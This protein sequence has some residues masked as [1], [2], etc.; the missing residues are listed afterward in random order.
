MRIPIRTRLAMIYCS[1][2]CAS[3]ILLE[4]G[5]YAALTSSIY[6]VTDNAL[7]ARLSGVE[8][9]L[10]EHVGRRTL[11]Q[12]QSE[13]ATHGALE[14]RFL[15][16]H[17]GG[18]GEIFRGRFLLRVGDTRP[19]T[20]AEVFWNLNQGGAPLRILSARRGIKNQQ[21]DLQVAADLTVPDAM[22]RRFLWL[23]LLTSPIVFT[24]AAAAGYWIGKRALLPV[25][26]LTNAARS[27]TAANLGERLAVSQSGD[28]VQ[29]LAETLNDMLGRIEGA[30]RHV[31]QFTANASHE[32]R[33][34]IALIRTASEVA[35]LRANGNAETYREALHR[36]LREAEKNSAL[37][38]DML[39]LARADASSAPLA[40][41]PVEL[42]AHINRLCE[43]VLPLAQEKEIRLE[44]RIPKS[45][46]WVMADGAH[47]NRLCLILL[48]NAIKY[49][50][51]GGSVVVSWQAASAEMAV[52]QVQDTGIGISEADLPH[53]FERFFR[54]DKARSR[55]EG[56]AGLGLALA[57]WIVEAHGAAIEVESKLGQG[58]VFRFSLLRVKRP[59]LGG[60]SAALQPSVDRQELPAEQASKDLFERTYNQ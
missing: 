31:T 43:R 15:R 33:A 41:K 42:G 23:F 59:G 48:D 4:M 2:F 8:G 32:L 55:E 52:C 39:H 9:F 54:A 49:T 24:F 21:Y 40:L 13:I 57:R 6:A 36:I 50:P 46:L 26:R 17:Q 3:A 11:P 12:L 37:L 10:D 51:V 16:I 14:P 18:A 35:L 56:G 53:I 5:S 58:S 19:A 38:D 20:T 44:Q 7:R 60:L 22:L 28:E 29:D 1:V 45:R 25:S 47:L 30:F 27:I 34:P